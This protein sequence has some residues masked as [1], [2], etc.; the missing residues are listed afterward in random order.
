M[1]TTLK[2]RFLQFVLDKE[3]ILPHSRILVAVSGGVDSMTLLH[4]LHTWQRRLQVELGVVH[5]HHHI[6]GAAADADAALVRSWCTENEIPFFL[7][8]EDVPAVAREKKLS[9]EEAGFLVRKQRFR[10]LA[11][12]EGFTAIAT[13]HHADDQAETVL[14]RLLLGTG[15]RGLAGI[16]LHQGLWIRPLL[17]ARRQEIEAYARYYRVPF[18]E[19]VSNREEKFLRNKIRHQ[20]L[21]YLQREFNPAVVEH[22]VG[23]SH[24]FQ[25]WEVYLREEVEKT[26]NR[27]VH[28]P[29]ENEIALEISAYLRY[30]SWIKIAVLERIFQQK[31]GWEKRI[32]RKEWES[33]E[34][35]LKRSG[36]GKSFRWGN[37]VVCFR[38]ADQVW[39]YPLTAEEQEPYQLSLFPD[40]TYHL[41]LPGIKITISQVAREAIRFHN[42]RK[43]EYLCGDRFRF[44]LLVRPWKTGERFI[45]LGATY[46]VLISDYL[47][48]SGIRQPVKKNYPVLLNGTEIVAIPGVQIDDRYKI[49]DNCRIIY[50][51]TI[52]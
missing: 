27:V 6:R 37:R 52:S 28:Q 2:N 39:F 16:R 40:K 43:E 1:Q 12:R 48:D 36:D 49:T 47:N 32:Q 35:W 4:L 44:P 13:G 26:W 38:Q 34:R 50:R 3:L 31:F 14:E 21:P 19:D 42:N 51:L 7:L 33:F 30:F 9:L 17:F 25:E 45:P 23:L 10:E 24:I 5:L 46:S 11:A 18:R 41:P 15:P 8:E 20:L 29:A 22:L